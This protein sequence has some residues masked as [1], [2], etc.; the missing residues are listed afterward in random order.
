MLQLRCI[1]LASWWALDA[2]PPRAGPSEGPLKRV[3]DGLPFGLWMGGSQRPVIISPSL[4]IFVWEQRLRKCIIT[5][6]EYHVSC[7]LPS[8]TP[9]VFAHVQ[10]V[11][12]WELATHERWYEQEVFLFGRFL[13]W[14]PDPVG[15][16]LRILWAL[17]TWFLQ[18]CWVRFGELHVTTQREL[19]QCRAKDFGTTSRTRELSIH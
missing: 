19:H 4:H 12:G 10:Q 9:P 14:K 5:L 3:V 15:L 1:R 13:D 11:V 18:D 7:P 2:P 8:L 17:L 16:T 6:T